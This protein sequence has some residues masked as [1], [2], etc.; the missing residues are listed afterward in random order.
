[1]GPAQEN[2][3]SEEVSE[4]QCPRCGAK[5]SVAELPQ[6][7]EA[8]RESFADVLRQVA[9]PVTE[10]QG[11]VDHELGRLLAGEANDLHQVQIA[12][13]KSQIQFQ[14]LLQTRNKLLQAYQEILRMQV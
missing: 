10:A 8:T 12:M 2:R 3:M 6:P 11:E 7:A 13:E 4:K 5:N 9:R 14:L 1:M